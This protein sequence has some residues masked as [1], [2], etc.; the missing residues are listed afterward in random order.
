MFNFDTP[1][2]PDDY[3]HRIG[4]TGRAGAL[5]R[6]FTF[7]SPEDAEAVANVEKLTGGPIPLYEVA[8]GG[9]ADRGD[10]A[11]TQ[12]EARE[13]PARG[14][15]GAERPRRGERSGGESSRS[16]GQDSRPRRQG[17]PRDA[18]GAADAVAEADIAAVAEVAQT[19]A[20]REPRGGREPR[21]PREA[22]PARTSRAP[23]EAEGAAP[24]A[25]RPP[26]KAEP[27]VRARAEATPRAAKAA[28]QRGGS[29]AKASEAEWNGPVPGFLGFSALD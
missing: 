10:E 13:R 21:V 3:V 18:V 9:S 17:V 14:E 12:R 20:K 28:A 4:R 6:A 26:E 1:W 2:H 19:A 22:R 25:G 11:E 27:R 8:T 5:G 7:V 16:R 23:R 24:E 15:R 29:T